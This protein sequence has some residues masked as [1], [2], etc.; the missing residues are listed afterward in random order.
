MELSNSQQ[1][2]ITAIL[3][4]APDLGIDTTKDTYSRA[5]LRQVSMRLKGKV[6]IPNWITH[7]VS[8]RT[9]RGIFSIP[10]I[11]EQFNAQ[12]VS[13]GHGTEGDDLMD[14]IEVSDDM[15]AHT[16]SDD[17]IEVTS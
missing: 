10:E 15:G 7:D 4:H 5:E 13:P 1:S 8:R 17:M 11:A 6:W 16:V 12:A 9:G 14:T 3:E 2:Y